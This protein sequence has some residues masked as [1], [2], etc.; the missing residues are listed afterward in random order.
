VLAKE[1]FTMWIGE[2][3]KVTDRIDF[4]GTREICLYLLKG[5]EAMIIGG[6]MS[7]IAPSME[8]QFPQM[9][10]DTENIKYLAV[11]HSHLDHCGAVP[12][13]KRKFPQLQI[14]AS[15]YSREVFSKE[16]V[17]NAI[18]SA[19]KGALNAL[20]LQDEYEKLNLNFDGI[21]VDRV[22]AENDFIDIGDGIEA[23]FIET[24][25]HT[26]CSLAVYVPKLK[27][28]FPSDA[29][30]VPLTDGSGLTVPSPQY[31]FLLYVES[32]KKLCTYEVEICAFEHNGVLLGEQARNILLLGLKQTEKFKNYVIDQYKETDDLD[33]VAQKLASEMQEKNELPFLTPEL[34]LNISKAAVRKI[35]AT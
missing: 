28:M 6:G 2:P 19:N 15:E 35:L 16:K 33:K 14:L 34:R 24:P 30:P 13:L 4:L 32:L 5:K 7:H 18:A 3:G 8:V 11:T 1:T 26:K 23:Y 22:M 17:V 27:A 31:D 20:G 21:H 29:A 10:F 12:Y 25:G 9:D